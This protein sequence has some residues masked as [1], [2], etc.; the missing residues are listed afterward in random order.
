M[1]FICVPLSI[2]LCAAVNLSVRRCQFVCAPLSICLCAAVNLSVRRCQFVCAPLSI[3]RCT[4]CNDILQHDRLISPEHAS[5][6]VQ[7]EQV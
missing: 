6:A 2:C 4:K 1:P 3:C 7:R 5:D